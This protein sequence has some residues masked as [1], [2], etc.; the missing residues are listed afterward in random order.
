MK[1]KPHPKHFAII[2][3]ANYQ[4]I[5]L[6]GLQNYTKFIFGDGSI[7]LMS[8]S[9]KNYDNSLN[10]PFIRVSKSCIVN[11]S[12]FSKICSENKKINLIDGSEIQIS[13][14]RFNEVL[15]NIETIITIKN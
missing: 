2:K 7:K 15:K 11:L 3:N 1:N 5:R 10:F 13:R 12:F 6:E 4:V 14:R 9:L 8:Y